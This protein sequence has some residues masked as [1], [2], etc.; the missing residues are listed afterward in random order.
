MCSLANGNKIL[1]EVTRVSYLNE[2]G[3]THCLSLRHRCRD[4]NGPEDMV[5]LIE[6]FPKVQNSG[7][8]PVSSKSNAVVETWNASLGRE[9]GMSSSAI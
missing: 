9:S 4:R 8:S 6:Y 3:C 7:H 2:A 1:D 5:Q